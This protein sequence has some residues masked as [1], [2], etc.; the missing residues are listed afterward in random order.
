MQRLSFISVEFASNYIIALIN[1]IVHFFYMIWLKVVRKWQLLIHIINLT[2]ES[3]FECPKIEAEN[4][5]STLQI[6]GGFHCDV[7]ISFNRTRV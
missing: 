4:I 2:Y 3:S 6:Q 7:I 1:Q 5:H